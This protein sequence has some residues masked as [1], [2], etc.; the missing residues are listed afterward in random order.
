MASKNNTSEPP[1][2]SPASSRLEKVKVNAA[3]LALGS[4]ASVAPASLAT[5]SAL[6]TTRYVLR[7]AIR[8]LI[9]YAKY[10][11]I[12]AI[13]AALGGTLLGTLGSGIAFF[14]APSIG[15]G[16]GIGVITAIAKFGWRHRGPFFRGG[17]W[18]SMQARAAEGRDGA[19]DEAMDAKGNEEAMKKEAHRRRE[20]VWM[21]A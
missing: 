10:A 20:D 16:M 8:R 13:A 5:R 14:A 6:T 3:Y 4:K 18:E 21:R 19:A 11:A 15:V 7:Y 9:R 2:A 12:G 1:P 17:V